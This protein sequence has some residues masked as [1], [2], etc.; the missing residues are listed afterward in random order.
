MDTVNAL[1]PP[2][3]IV[4]GVDGSA[5]ADRAVRWA[6][7][8]ADLCGRPLILLHA[9]DPFS[10]ANA[11]WMSTMA[12][13]PA[14]VR[15]DA[16]VAAR[17]L[18]ARAA[19]VARATHPR[20]EAQTIT[21]LLDPRQAL[22]KA[23]GDADLVV[24]GSR[25][26]GPVASLVLGSVSAAVVK[27]ATSPVVV[28]RPE[29]THQSERTGI[30][31]GLDCR[32]PEPE[33]LEAAYAHASLRQ[34]PLTV[35]HCF[36]DVLGTTH[37]SRIVPSDD[38]SVDDLRALLSEATAGMSERYPEVE[39]HAELARGF[40]EELLSRESA[41]YDLVVVGH[42]ESSAWSSFVHGSVAL[43][44]AEL[45]TSPVLVVPMKTSASWTA[46]GQAGLAAPARG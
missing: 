5:D 13:D 35:M 39:V 14:Q 40:A 10:T 6:A 43:A 44:V 38:S 1:I 20:V 45:A 11:L 37:A 27:H 2:G 42:H 32:R 4:V 19:D 16:E 23:S 3:S 22:I 8:E 25:G 34:L 7:E 15:H 21:Q 46:Q 30:L 26:R 9:V 36:W 18:L 17:A 24:V 33:V 31:V 41:F 12:I 28:V 29:R